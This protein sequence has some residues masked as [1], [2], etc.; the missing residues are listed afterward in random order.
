MQNLPFFCLVD[1]NGSYITQGL[2]LGIILAFVVQV[3]FYIVI[4]FRT[5]MEE[6]VSNF[7]LLNVY[8]LIFVLLCF[9]FLCPFVTFT[10]LLMNS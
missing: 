10:Q 2:W 8:V 3:L 6:Q 4:A 1:V 7:K 9:Q 5:D